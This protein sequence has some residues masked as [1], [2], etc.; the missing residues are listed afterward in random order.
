MYRCF[1]L[2]VNSVFSWAHPLQSLRVHSCQHWDRQVLLWMGASS[3][4]SFSR[5]SKPVGFVDH[6]EYSEYLSQ[7]NPKHY[8]HRG[9][10]HHN[11]H[12][13]IR[14]PW[15]MDHG[16]PAHPFAKRRVPFWWGKGDR[17]AG[18]S[19]VWKTNLSPDSQSCK[20]GGGWIGNCILR[21]WWDSEEIVWKDI[22]LVYICMHKCMHMIICIYIYI[23]IYTY[24][25]MHI[26]N[27]HMDI[28]TC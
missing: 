1:C 17:G 28:H 27:M 15:T 12:P 14:G 25:R 11:H 10:H 23:C 20:H 3:Q 18:P 16:P 6:N 4:V 26:Y 19:M 24:I 13:H 9:R 5:V 21:Q 22:D 2:P 8:H 7:L